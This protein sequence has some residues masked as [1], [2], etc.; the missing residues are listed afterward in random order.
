M[1]E[2]QVVVRRFSECEEKSE[3][4]RVFNLLRGSVEQEVEWIVE[5]EMFP[6]V[7]CPNIRP[8][9][10]IW[11][12]SLGGAVDEEPYATMRVSGK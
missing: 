12:N 2:V 4:S 7:R 3:V 1:F 6:V 5:R 10:K 9:V 8:F 11:Q